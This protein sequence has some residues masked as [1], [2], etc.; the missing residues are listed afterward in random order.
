MCFVIRN[1]AIRTKLHQT[2]SHIDDSD[3]PFKVIDQSA[4][5]RTKLSIYIS[6]RDEHFRLLLEYS[7]DYIYASKLFS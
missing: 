6:I 1:G 3:F 2:N 7:V 4:A 5:D